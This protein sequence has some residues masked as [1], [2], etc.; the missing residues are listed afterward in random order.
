LN[1][2]QASAPFLRFTRDKNGYDNTYI[3]LTVREDGRTR[4]RVLYWFHGPSY[5]KVGRTALDDRVRHELEEA[6]PNVRFEWD[7]LIKAQQGALAAEA[8]D[9]RHRRR[10]R[11]AA[12]APPVAAAI[13][14]A[15]EEGEL[16]APAAEP[17]GKAPA[18]KRRRRRGRGHRA[19]GAPAPGTDAL[20]DAPEPGEGSEPGEPDDSG[21]PQV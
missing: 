8:I 5:A 21:E 1:G 12:G 13:A 18:R 14:A 11:P 2:S 20:G 7:A 15:P 16:D 19:D 9:A 10:E 4:L 17:Q 6:Y 3:V